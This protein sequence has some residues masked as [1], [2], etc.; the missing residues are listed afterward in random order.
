MGINQQAI[1]HISRNFD[2]KSTD[3]FGID[4]WTDM[5]SKQCCSLR[6]TLMKICKNR[7]SIC[8]YKIAH[9]SFLCIH[10]EQS[11]LMSLEWLD[12]WVCHFYDDYCFILLLC[13]YLHEQTRGTHG[14]L[15]QVCATGMYLSLHWTRRMS[16]ISNR[17][18]CWTE[19]ARK[20][21]WPFLPNQ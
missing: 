9:L 2:Q 17:K 15:G 16:E 21:L 3:H 13:L 8:E 1:A 12:E 20:L 7:A 5:L 4:L 14:S 11:R 19:S 10:A 6:R 18:F